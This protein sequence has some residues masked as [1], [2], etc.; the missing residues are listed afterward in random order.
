MFETATLAE[1]EKKS[2]RAKIPV[3]MSLKM[4]ATLFLKVLSVY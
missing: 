1:V 2:K 4:Q 3:P